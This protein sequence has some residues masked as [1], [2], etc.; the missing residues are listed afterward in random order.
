M[1]SVARPRPAHEQEGA[2]PRPDQGTVGPGG[3]QR[4]ADG[5]VLVV[6]DD[7]AIRTLVAMALA[8]EGY[9]VAV[10]PNGRAALERLRYHR[11]RLILL[12]MR[13]PE[14][15][16]WEFAR[17]YRTLP[18]P[19]APIVVLAAAVDVAAEGAQIGAAAALGKP[20][21]LEA[22]LAVVARYAGP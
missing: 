19:H 5:C 1:D 12:D 7:P 18:G 21:D 6:D 3:E 9:G 15:D 16:G 13:M 8:D 22:L 20:F 11:P 17:R 4:A 14:M 10:A 2:P